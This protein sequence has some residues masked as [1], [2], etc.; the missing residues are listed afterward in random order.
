MPMGNLYIVATPIGNL[1]DT[2]FRAGKLIL[3]TSVLVTEST[4][5]ANIL[6]KFLE[7]E[8]KDVATNKKIISL[9]QE[10]EINKIPMVI[11]ILETDDIVLISEAGTPLV[12]DPGYK[13]VR[14]AI[15]R[16]INVIPIPGATAVMAALVSSGLPSDSFYFMGFLPKQQSKI[17]KKL[18]ELKKLDKTTVI[19][20][21][22]PNRCVETINAIK[23][24]FGNVDMVIAR[25]LT[26]IHEEITR[27]TTDEV[28]TH[29]QGKTI[30]GEITI[31]FSTI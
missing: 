2:T 26:K 18:S 3:S 27:G 6:I 28:L 16:G 25:E 14:E 1:Q 11:K 19:L 5:K 22:S 4:S 17:I 24:V 21:E 10:E 23:E 7:N 30:K 9:N 8:L 13:L 12:S 29:I 15:K 20:Y 31:L